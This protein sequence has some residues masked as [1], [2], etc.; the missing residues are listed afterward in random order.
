M[1]DPAGNRCR[2]GE[3]ESIAKE[4]AE[5]I[6]SYASAPLA[7]Q[8]IERARHG[9]VDT[10]LDSRLEDMELTQ[11]CRGILDVMLKA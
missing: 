10:P 2:L 4:R 3:T 8:N 9:H 11:G 5:A 1:C 7:L 6:N